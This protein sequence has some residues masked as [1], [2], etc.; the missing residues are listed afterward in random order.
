LNI[1]RFLGVLLLDES[2]HLIGGRHVETY[3]AFT[4]QYLSEKLCFFF[5]KGKP[6]IFWGRASRLNGQ[7]ICG[8]PYRLASSAVSEK[9]Q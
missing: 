9:R 8:E 1:I 4:A 6:Y 7:V 5:Y 2:L 3:E